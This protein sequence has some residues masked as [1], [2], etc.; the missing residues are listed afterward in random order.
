M[1]SISSMLEGYSSKSRASNSN[2]RVYEKGRIFRL[3]MNKEQAQAQG[4]ILNK[5]GFVSLNKLSKQ[6]REQLRAVVEQEQAQ[7]QA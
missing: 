2:M 7:E 3:Y 4:V 6:E 1:N 5:Q